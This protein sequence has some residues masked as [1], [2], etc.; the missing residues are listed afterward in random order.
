MSKNK[1]VDSQ[2]QMMNRKLVASSAL[3]P[4]VFRTSDNKKFLQSTVDQ[5]ISPASLK[6][7]NHY[8]GETRTSSFSGKDS[9]FISST[10]DRDNYQLTPGMVVNDRAVK[11]YIDFINYISTVNGNVSNHNNVTKQDFY[12]WDPLISIDKF[13]NF[14]NYYWLPD[15][16]LNVTIPVVS[17][18][19]VETDIIGQ[20]NA[21]IEG[22]RL[23]NGM[24][25]TLVGNVSN[26]Q[27][28]GKPLYV[29]GVGTSI[30]L[31]DAV[32]YDTFTASAPD[33]FVIDKNS[34][35]IN[36][37]NLTNKWVHVDVIKFSEAYNNQIPVFDETLKAARPIIEF[38]SGIKLFNSGTNY[39][40]TVDLVDNF[41]SDIFSIVNGSYGY[42]ID[43]IDLVTGMTILVTNDSN[44]AINNSIYEVSIIDTVLGEVLALEKIVS[45]TANDS[46]LIKQGNNYKNTMFWVDGVTCKPAQQ[47]ETNNK[48]PLFDVFD[49]Q[50]ISFA[51]YT[52]STFVGTTFFSYAK[53]AGKTDDVLGFPLKYQNISNTGDISFNYT[54]NTDLFEY[55]VGKDVIQKKVNEGYVLVGD[56]YCNGWVKNALTTSQPIVREFL[57]SESPFVIDVFDDESALSQSTVAAFIDG[58]FVSSNNWELTL[59]TTIT[60][61]IS[62]PENSVISF[63]IYSSTAKNSNG[64]YKLP[65]NL[66]NNPLNEEFT[67]LTFGQIT[68]HVETMIIPAPTFSGVFPGLSNL[69]DLDV[70][71][72]GTKLVKHTSPLNLSLYH[73][74][75]E[76]NILNA[77]SYA[78]EKYTAYKGNFI[79]EITNSGFSGPSRLHVDSILSSISKFGSTEFIN[80]DM[81]GFLNPV[82]TEFNITSLYNNIFP[83]LSEFDDS[84]LST[85]AVT[86][87]RN[88]VQLIKGIDY[89]FENSQV[90][91][92]NLS[93]NDTIQIVEYTTTSNTNC[94]PTPAKLGIL[95]AYIPKIFCDT[96]STPIFKDFYSGTVFVIDNVGNYATKS[97][98][99]VIIENYVSGVLNQRY[100]LEN[101]QFSVTAGNNQLTVT[102]SAPI[103]VGATVKVG[104]PPVLIRGH[105]GCLMLAFN[106]YRDELILEFETRIFNN[107][108][109]DASLDILSLIPGPYRD[110]G[111][112]LDDINRLLQPDFYKWSS[113]N[114]DSYSVNTS[115]NEVLPSTFNHQLTLLATGEYV[116]GSTQ[117]IYQW[118]FDTT[119]PNLCPWECAGFTIKPSWWDSSYGAAPYTSNNL[120]LWNDLRDGKLTTPSGVIDNN[121][122]KRDILAYGAPVDQFGK[123]LAFAESPYVAASYGVSQSWEFGDFSPIEYAWRR[124][125]YYQFSLIKALVTMFPATMFGKYFD[126]SRVSYN[127]LG[128]VMYN[129]S[130]VI[131]LDRLV[132][133]TDGIELT[134]GLVNYVCDYIRNRDSISINEYANELTSVQNKLVARLE[135]FSSKQKLQVKIDSKVNYASSYFIPA[136]NY[137]ILLNS[138]API[139]KVSYSGVLVTKV[140]AGYEIRGY[141]STTPNFLFYQWNET[142]KSFNIG[143]ISESFSNWEENKVYVAGTVVRYNSEYY[144]VLST[145]TYNIVDSKNFAKLNELPFA[146][147]ITVSSRTSW[148][149]NDLLTITYGHIFRTEQEVVDFM[150]GY[151]RYLKDQ[152]F[153]FDQFDSVTGQPMDWN[154]GIMEF[155]F[156]ASQGWDAGAVIS[157][158]PLS[159]RIKLKTEKVDVLDIRNGISGYEIYKVD[160][161]PLLIKDL[162]VIREPEYFILENRDNRTGIFGA[163]F[164]LI[165]KEHVVIFDNITNFNDIIYDTLSGIQQPRI[166]FVGEVTDDWNGKLFAPGFIYDNGDVEEWKPWKEYRLGDTVKYKEFYFVAENII[167]A[168]EE[169][170]FE[171]W[172][173][174]QNIPEATLLPNLDQKANRL[175]SLYEVDVIESDVSLQQTARRLVSYQPRDYLNSLIESEDSRFKFFQ[176]MIREK[177]TISVLGALLNVFSDNS[178][179]VVVDE[180]W[181]VRVGRFGSVDTVKE[182]EISLM[183]TDIQ[184]NPQAVAVTSNKTD[185]DFVT[186]VMVETVVSSVNDSSLF[187]RV[188][189]AR[190]FLRTPGPLY[191][192]D[193]KLCIDQL[194]EILEHNASEL[195]END[196]VWCPFDKNAWNVYLFKKEQPSVTNVELSTNTVVYL[197]NAEV[198]SYV[199]FDREFLIPAGVGE[200]FITILGDDDITTS[201]DITTEFELGNTI[202]DANGVFGVEVE[203]S[204]TNT[205]NQGFTVESLT[206]FVRTKV[207]FAHV[208]TDTRTLSFVITKNEI[209]DNSSKVRVTFKQPAFLPNQYVGIKGS[210]QLAGFYKIVETTDD[211]ISIKTLLDE[212]T[213]DVS[214]VTLYSFVPQY[215]NFRN[216]GESVRTKIPEV[217]FITDV[218][219]IDLT[220]AKTMT[221]LEV[222]DVHQGVVSKL[223]E[224]ELSFKTY[225]DPA[226]YSDTTVTS[227]AGPAAGQ[228]WVENNVGKLWWDLTRAK[229]I[230]NGIYTSVFERS[231]L[232]NKLYKTAS[233]DIYEWVESSLTPAE[234]DSLNGTA[235]ATA[236]RVSGLSK[237]G[238]NAYS[239]KRVFDNEIDDFV[240]VYYFWVKNPNIIYST[241]DNRTLSAFEVS[242]IIADPVSYGL[243]CIG[244]LGKNEFVIANAKKFLGNTTVVKF[245]YQIADANNVAQHS[246]WKLISDN[247]FS[248]IPENIETKWIDS[249]VGED[250]DGNV[251]PLRNIPERYRYGIKPE[252]SMFI[253]KEA[254]L[255]ICIAKI[256]EFMKT[257]LV[258]EEYDMST[259]LTSEPAPALTN[260][261]LWDVTV[262]DVD[263]LSAISIA[264]LQTATLSLQI[265]EGIIV[266]VTIIDSGKGYK[267]APTVTIKGKGTAAEILLTIDNQGQVTGA[268]VVSGG[269]NYDSTTTASVRAFSVLVLHNTEFFDKWT[270]CDWKNNSWNITRIQTHDVTRFWKYIDWYKDS[271]YSTQIVSKIVNDVSEINITPVEI[272]ELIK[273]R[274]YRT[275]GWAVFKKVNDINNVSYSLNFELVARENGTIQFIDISTSTQQTS[276]FDEL[277][278][279]QY[280]FDN[281]PS[282]EIRKILTFVRDELLVGENYEEYVALFFSAVRYVMSEQLYT[283]WIFKTSYVNILINNGKLL[284]SSVYVA[285]KF[286]EKEAFINEVKPYRSKIREMIN[287]FG[288]EDNTNSL[289][290]DFDLPPV[291]VDNNPVQVRTTYSTVD[292]ITVTDYP[293]LAD[294]FPWEMWAQNNLFAL[295]KVEIYDTGENYSDNTVVS[296]DGSDYILSPV[297]VDGKIT[298]IV[299]VKEGQPLVSTPNISIIDNNATGSGCSAFAKL[300][301][302]N[303]RSPKVELK[304]DRNSR[305]VFNISRTDSQTFIVSGGQTV[306]ELRYPASLIVGNTVF[307]NDEEILSTDWEITTVRS[308]VDGTT[309]ERSLLTIS[310]DVIELN[311]VVVVQYTKSAAM[312]NAIDRINL[313]YMPYGKQYGKGNVIFDPSQLMSGIDY[314][315]SVI[316]GGSTNEELGFDTV[317]WD[318][319][320]LDRVVDVYTV[321]FTVTDIEQR[322]YV[323]EPVPQLDDVV[324]C[325]QN[326]SRIDYDIRVD[327][328]DANKMET[329]IGNG[330]DSVITIPDNI[331]LDLG[332]TL[333]FEVIPSSTVDTYIT[334]GSLETLGLEYITATGVTP[335]EIAIDSEG[336]ITPATSFAPEEMLP[337][338]V[339]DTVSI[340]VYT[341]TGVGNEVYGFMQFKDMLNRTHYIRLNSEKTFELAQ[342]LDVLDETVVLNGIGLT[343]PGAIYVGGE[344][345]SYAELNEVGLTTELSQLTRGTLGTSIPQVHDQ[346]KFAAS[347]SAD[348]YIPGQNSDPYADSETKMISMVPFGKCIING[349]EMRVT[350]EHSGR[351]SIG[352]VVSIVIDRFSNPNVVTDVTIISFN[353]LDSGNR[354]YS[355]DQT[356]SLPEETMFTGIPQER[357]NI[358]LFV[359]PA[360]KLVEMTAEEVRDKYLN[361]FNVFV[362]NRR[363]VKGTYSRE[364]AM[365]TD[366]NDNLVFDEQFSQPIF[367]ENGGEIFTDLTDYQYITESVSKFVE[368]TY[369]TSK[370]VLIVK[371][372]GTL[373]VDSE[374]TQLIDSTTA[375]AEFLKNTTAIILN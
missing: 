231:Q 20:V 18:L 343:A 371:K 354:L 290:S 22:V 193:V 176:G 122:F 367:V 353:G 118:L 303:V 272:G 240:N 289:I 222:I 214:L 96:G 362:A 86:V 128:Q 174:L 261:C 147:G 187:S 310:Q 209:V 31:V 216:Y 339:V 336:F 219:I 333:I 59:G 249:L 57:S 100:E 227:L 321:E 351:L 361:R 71:R 135:G 50:G 186:K 9:Y 68:S 172:T 6:K 250:R 212:F 266:G 149:K 348:E 258:S 190:E 369:S 24:K 184:L 10:A 158:S 153:V 364:G 19:N 136:E 326:G 252:Q 233:I 218:S 282:T 300:K 325:Y 173:A 197:D 12:T 181:A 198:I 292:G 148:N 269:K 254:A 121:K 165:Q 201:F 152:G 8:F 344:R 52:S 33:Y 281:Y 366:L 43:G 223:A 205:L 297:I 307:V 188:T 228:V 178:D 251:I 230:D 73:L 108:K 41:T 338:H 56:T 115:F 111:Y 263:S 238:M 175:S 104:I 352:S 206:N 91:V 47:K 318:T 313:M 355:I 317:G 356:L 319:D 285:P 120:V 134:S 298:E 315:G 2:G 72:N 260:P 58:K 284:Q 25:I 4:A 40:A 79:N 145:G 130:G 27:Y 236:N 309:L 139:G 243:P 295:D 112:V 334:G 287:R 95:P 217:K 15:G 61:N 265:E 60:F 235:R 253:D 350:E 144:R 133:P 164:Y 161:S 99:T 316:S 288:T 159:Q 151:D 256:N 262:D 44:P 302:N 51:D 62:L 163:T 89:T 103:P 268:T 77:I 81:F 124:S 294:K 131:S 156:W 7:L 132:I 293:Q 93:L 183:D 255:S 105:D 368:L 323:I 304:F 107:I 5:L 123:L 229:F 273:V 119:R 102:V 180:E 225:Y 342:D 83:L 359:E 279:D 129:T 357:I 63:E 215:E 140:S 203:D 46:V 162:R 166:K 160:G 202:F 259:I 337:G 210:S 35:D 117:G 16:V 143:G 331:V 328:V 21:T 65:V 189:N 36:I 88:G 199:T 283:D 97:D 245:E 363:L 347:V 106:D 127:L 45:L 226:I 329:F 110:T 11:D 54:F 232:W 82:V 375:P 67:S 270:L 299:I 85:T 192:T 55:T 170:K 126:V 372:E 277:F 66:Q 349:T 330:I 224:K 195:E 306:F 276:K 74:T 69:Q 246:Q 213:D 146:G 234:W 142:G 167:Q 171:E 14:R 314:G 90:V 211:S 125:S 70:I 116:S 98:V 42:N 358:S 177:G 191:Y 87:Y 141:S 267:N 114:F 257:S 48:E 332:D 322:E 301:I 49:A 64:Y 248:S 271:Q 76:N 101:T 346:G 244:V 80:S 137:K 168:K 291:F 13:V 32:V 335:T 29:Y 275:G 374:S 308:L 204:L 340:Q 138:S 320:V 23:A 220:T 312:F 345:I 150:Y 278:F 264:N 37:W 274:S 280:I 324:H 1:F 208:S 341:K 373:W 194:S 155:L 84:S 296:A 75:S 239:I 305:S 34:S 286:A 242:Q 247:K 237:Y 94:P 182:L 207:T 28:V 241:D 169:F 185:Y 53:G 38:R 30:S 327:T 221:D 200:V 39:V 370:D 26:Y 196:F 92:L 179:G 109:I 311:D 3:L 157:I 360:D 113:E 17:L 154:T 78:A 365:L